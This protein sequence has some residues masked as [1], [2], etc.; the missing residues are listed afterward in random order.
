[1]RPKP[2]PCV[3][4]SLDEA[5]LLIGQIGERLQVS[6]LF[7]SLIDRAEVVCK[8]DAPAE[9]REQEPRESPT[10]D[11]PEHDE[12]QIDT[13]E[14]SE[15]RLES[16]SGPGEPFLASVAVSSKRGK[17]LTRLSVRG[18]FETGGSTS[19]RCRWRWIGRS[20]ITFLLQS[21]D[22]RIDVPAAFADVGSNAFRIDPVAGSFDLI[23]Y[24][25]AEFLPVYRLLV[26]PAGFHASA[27]IHWNPR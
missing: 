8:P 26:V 27:T 7:E 4:E 24:K 5:G 25:A 17:E 3:V 1:M 20:E 9:Q 18:A 16:P 12:E 21:V 23:D 22:E 11:A 19:R 14:R 13:G 10:G 2:G 15:V 6:T